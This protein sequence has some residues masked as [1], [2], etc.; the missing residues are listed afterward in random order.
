MQE[1]NYKQPP[2]RLDDPAY[3]LK[4]KGGVCLNWKGLPFW[5]VPTYGLEPPAGRRTNPGDFGGL[6]AFQRL[7]NDVLR[8]RGSGVP[9]SIMA[10]RPY[11]ADPTQRDDVVQFLGWATAEP[12]TWCVAGWPGWGLAWL[13]LG[14]PGRCTCSADGAA[15]LP[16][17]HPSTIQPCTHPN[18]T[19]ARRFVTYQQLIRYMEAREEGATIEQVMEEYKCDEE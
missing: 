11:L 12:N 3:N 19:H 5:E 1:L 2:G 6:T 13:G 14:G 8:K 15:P 17:L 4:C 16:S 9:T 10:H 18:L 7:Q